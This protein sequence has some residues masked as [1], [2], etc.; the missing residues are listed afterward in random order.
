MRTAFVVLACVM[1]LVWACDAPRLQTDAERA[2]ESAVA[3]A[4]RAMVE[5]DDRG[6]AR[7]LD[8]LAAVPLD[9]VRAVNVE[10][11]PDAYGLRATMAFRVGREVM[12]FENSRLART[13]ELTEE[14]AARTDPA[15]VVAA[16][17]RLDA[18]LARLFDSARERKT[19]AMPRLVGGVRLIYFK[20]MRAVQSVDLPP[21]LEQREATIRAIV[22]AP[23]ERNVSPAEFVQRGV[24]HAGRALAAYGAGDGTAL[25]AALD[26][27]AAFPSDLLKH[28]PVRFVPEAGATN[29][30]TVRSSTRLTVDEREV[31]LPPPE[32]FRLSSGVV[33]AWVAER[34]PAQ[35]AGGLDALD[36]A[37]A[38]VALAANRQ[39]AEHA[40]SAVG[41]IRAQTLT[42]LVALGDA[43]PK[44][45]AERLAAVRATLVKP[46]GR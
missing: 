41:A 43:A 34:P 24:D 29:P 13:D 45:A 7:S 3:A 44:D 12:S 23:R 37:L 9:A 26:E 28:M 6:Y 22:K 38:A 42:Q 33:D 1:M 17:D 40:F 46:R 31:V 32:Q 4:L 35:A 30:G 18:A 36:V 10:V 8:D 20:R 5:S 2:A 14:W 11:A 27:L 25:R 21:D 16:L 19:I 15:V 39:G